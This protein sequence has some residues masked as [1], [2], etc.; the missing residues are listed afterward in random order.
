[1]SM[2]RVSRNSF[3]LLPQ[4]V[5]LRHFP[6]LCGAQTL[7]TLLDMASDGLYA[8]PS[9]EH[10]VSSSVSLRNEHSL[11]YTLRGV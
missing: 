8:S 3:Y 5:L 6:P 4:A 2:R 10:P 1:M 9:V 7:L 11:G